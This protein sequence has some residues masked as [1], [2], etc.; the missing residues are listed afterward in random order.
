MRIR[1]TVAALPGLI[2]AL[3]VHLGCSWSN[4]AGV[5]S[6]GSDKGAAG[7]SDS[8]GVSG[9]PTSSGA[10]TSGG[11]GGASI[12]S[13]GA[14]SGS[15]GAANGGAAVTNSGGTFS[16]G[17]TSSSAGQSGSGGTTVAS[18]LPSCDGGVLSLQAVWPMPATINGWPWAIAVDGQG[19]V[20]AAGSFEGSASFGTVVLTSNGPQDMFL[21]KFDSTGALV[22]ANR[23]GGDGYDD[24]TPALAVDD[25]GNAYLGGG[26]GQTLDFGGRTTPLVALTSDAFVAKIGPTGQTLWA[27][28]FGWAGETWANG[29][30]GYVYS[31]A[32]APGGDPV[33]AGTAGA[34]ITL[35]STNWTSAGTNSQ[36]FVARLKSADGSVVWGA[37][38]GGTFDTD[39]TFVTVDSQNRTFVAGRASSG[40]GAWGTGVGTFRVGFDASGKP[41]WSRF[42]QPSL[43]MGITVDAAGRLVVVEDVLAPTAA[44]TIGTTTFS[45]VSS[46]LVLLL[47]PIDGTLIS[48]AQISETFPNGVV[49][50]TRGNSLVTG[51]YWTPP[52]WGSAG[53]PRSGDQPLFLAAVDGTSKPAGLAGLGTTAGAQPY[54]IAMDL[55]GSGRIFVAAQLGTATTSSVGPIGAGQI[56]AVFGPDPCVTGGGPQGSMTGNAS[57]HGDLPPDGS[58][59]ITQPD[60]GTPAPCPA[61]SALAVNGAACP[62]KMGCPYGS[63]CCICIPT[64]CGGQ[65]TTWT[66]TTL[67]AP[68]PGCPASPPANGVAC[69]TSGLQ[70]TY[71]ASGGRQLAT[72]TAAGWQSGYAQLLCN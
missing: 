43:P 36:P 35:G 51:T 48:G 33:I 49:A 64:P 1:L 60:S 70:C 2:A 65:S 4:G 22:Y 8:G 29:G 61:S 14:T 47:S 71:C 56:I 55:S 62:V 21:A 7:G 68:D 32:I 44:V 63:E 53:L 17:F 5:G 72:C 46:A 18:D 58:A 24:S 40:G 23:Y 13:G 50:D 52:N 12:G 31:I 54:G 39:Q 45:A 6:G 57:D 28:R 9:G 10:G 37:A 3:C 30:S 20:Y 66:C 59:P 42:D 27:Q 41:M 15:G 16:G 67:A 19:N 69:S 11:R 25:V 38:S 34:T 26:F